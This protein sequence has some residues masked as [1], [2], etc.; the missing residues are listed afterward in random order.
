M[1]WYNPLSWFTA[2]KTEVQTV[3]QKAE[4]LVVSLENEALHT[5]EWFESTLQS[6][7][8]ELHDL[9]TRLEQDIADKTEA[10]Q[11]VKD[12]IAKAQSVVPPPVPAPAPVEPAPQ[13]AA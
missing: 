8:A 4:E 12:A 1:T 9:E 5:V 11:A 10:L 2:A 7:V 6:G 3:E 13:V